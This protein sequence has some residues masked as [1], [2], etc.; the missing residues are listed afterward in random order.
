MRTWLPLSLLLILLLAGASQAIPIRTAE[1]GAVPQREYTPRQDQ[2]FLSYYNFCSGWVF[3]WSGYCYGTFYDAPGLP[4]FGTCFDLADCPGECRHLEDV[5][6]AWRWWGPWHAID[7]EIY[8]AD[9]NSCP[10]GPPLAG[11]YSVWLGHYRP[12]AHFSFGGLELCP[13][14]EIGSGKFIVMLTYVQDY[15][16]LCP[17][18]DINSY[19]INEGCETDWR[20]TGHSYVY[21][22]LIPYCDIYGMP[23]P[24]WVSGATYGCTNYP[25]IPPG[26]HNYIYN[27]GFFTE[28]LID[29]YIS[30]LGATETERE[31]WGSVKRLFK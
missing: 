5:W 31:S 20:C 12:L 29:C 7:I 10:V 18:S 30:C 4:Q 13:C 26:C 8:C 11:F 15:E 14:E 24:M 2:C 19:N 17:Y 16:D 22:N 6:W 28:W 9:N 1:Q 25:P 3:Y 27:T 21:R 23:G